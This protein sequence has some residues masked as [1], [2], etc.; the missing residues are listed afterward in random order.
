[1]ELFKISHMADVVHHES[2]MTEVNGGSGNAFRRVK[3]QMLST[4]T[5]I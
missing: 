4:R 3:V 5:S 2:K 1:M